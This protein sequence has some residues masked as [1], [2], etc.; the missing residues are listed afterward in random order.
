MHKAQGLTMD[1][2]Y[3]SIVKV[4]GFGLPYTACTRTPFTHNMLFVGVPPHD[5]FLKSTSIDKD[6]KTLVDRK[7]AE[8]EV[9][10]DDDVALTAEIMQR[11]R[12]GVF[13]LEAMIAERAVTESTS[14]VDPSSVHDTDA[15]R[16]AIIDELKA[17]L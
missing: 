10:A 8:L 13:D 7:K 6:G 3:P 12:A 4:F 11:I 9:F 16:S 5:I 1:L 17:N 14:M 15:L 2:T